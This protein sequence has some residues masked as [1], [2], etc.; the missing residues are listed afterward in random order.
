[1]EDA[2]KIY[3][4]QLR[5][6]HVEKIR[7][8]FSPHFLDVDEKELKFIDD[9][10]VKGK[11]YLAEDELILNLD[12]ATKAEK[13]CIICNQPTKVDIAIKEF[14][15]AE[16]LDQ[17]K[18]GVFVFQDLLREN[19]LLE[20]PGFA[21]CHDGKCPQRREMTKYLKEKKTAKEES[22][23]EDEGYHPF[24]DFDWEKKTKRK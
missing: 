6:G 9:V 5:D 3:V 15:H 12:I 13:L 7:E 24:A 17:I 1:M 4:E 8:T 19:I 2:F 20:T 23:E 16:P 14:Y 21:E 22:K 18:S 10:V 11:A